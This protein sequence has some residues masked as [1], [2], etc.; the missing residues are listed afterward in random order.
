MS[1]EAA[2][3]ASEVAQRA[4]MKQMQ[5]YVANVQGLFEGILTDLLLNQPADPHAFLLEA[6]QSMPASETQAIAANMKAQDE[7]KYNQEDPEHNRA[8]NVIYVVLTLA[9]NED[10]AAKDAVVATL[11]EL[12]AYARSL[13]ACLRFDIGQNVNTTSILVNQTWASQ[14]GLDSYYESGEF[15]RATPKFRGLLADMPDERVYQPV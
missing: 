10:P 3:I 11:K 14:A 6:I 2:A 15:Q 8:K 4:Q 5:I 1:D 13:P 7:R 9:V 12:Q